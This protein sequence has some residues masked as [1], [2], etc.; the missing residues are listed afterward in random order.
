MCRI[1]FLEFFKINVGVPDL[2]TKSY[3]RKTV[4]LKKFKN[5]KYRFFFKLI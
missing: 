1:N 4:F 3:S 2:S 5:L